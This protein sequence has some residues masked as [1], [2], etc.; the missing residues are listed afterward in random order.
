MT[1]DA[2]VLPAST[3][4]ATSQL[5][6]RVRHRLIQEQADPSVPKVAALLR[7][8]GV[9]LGDD[10][11]LDLVERLRAELTGLG[12][13]EPLLRL[14]DVTD[15]LVNGPTQVWL[16]RDSGLQPADVR[17]SDEGS[18]RRL[19]LRLAGMAGRRLDESAP[20]VDAR[21]PNGIR[22]H[23]AI[24][25]AS[26][27][28]TVISLRIPR[29]RAFTLDDL[30]VMGSLPREGVRV[31]QSLISARIAF[32]V[33]G[34]TGT[35]KTTILSAL[36]GL[37]GPQERLLLVEDTGELQPDHPHV[38]RLETRPAN[39][40]GAG[41]ISMQ[42]LVRQALRMRPDRLVVGEVRGPEIID[43]LTALNTGHEGGCATLHA[44]S[45]ADVPAR[46]EALG[47]MAGLNRV[48][49]HALASA[50]LSAV[51]H[52]CRD[53]RGRR[54]VQGV[55]VIDRI[56]TGLRVLPAVEFG[57]TVEVYAEAERLVNLGV[58]TG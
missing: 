8:E 11:M 57:D 31:L 56:D 3:G 43:L 19:A 39:V 47:F 6:E 30:V 2:A 23:A 15:I 36:L 25:P 32:L 28:G 10:M 18:V 52:V 20:F 50:G 16:D 5:I 42:T 34:G 49:I 24:P 37:V 51:V 38:V 54:R 14:P 33:T 58:R 4:L 35:G 40:E 17:F 7:S 27:A 13:L 53:R 12:V 55:H 21:L 41:S 45:A 26:P 9:V 1:V 29:R 44:N 46:L 22:L 48:A